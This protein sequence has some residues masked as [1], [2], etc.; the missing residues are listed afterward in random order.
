MSVQSGQGDFSAIAARNAVAAETLPGLDEV[1]RICALPAERHMEPGEVE[2][3]SRQELT[4][5]AWKSGMRLWRQQAEADMAFQSVGG[6]FAPLRVAGGKSIISYLAAKHAIQRTGVERVML[7]VPSDLISKSIRRDVPFMRETID[8]RPQVH[9]VGGLPPA[10]RLHL[11]RSKWR[12]VY[13]YPYSLL[14]EE[15]AD[16]EIGLIDPDVVVADE[17]HALRGIKTAAS[18]KRFMRMMADRPKNRRRKFAGLSGTMAKRSLK[19]YAHL[20]LLALPDNCPAPR[21]PAEVE[22]WASALDEV[23]RVWEEDDSLDSMRTLEPMRAWAEDH[24]KKGFFSVEEVGGPLTADAEG[25][26]RAFRLRRNSAQ[27]VVA[28]AESALGVSLKM[29]NRPAPAPV[30]EGM[31]E[32]AI[33]DLENSLD[34]RFTGEEFFTPKDVFEKEPP[35][36]KLLCLLWAV[37][38]I[39]TRKDR[40]GRATTPNGDVIEYGIHIHKWAYE[41]C[42]GFYHEMVWPTIDDLMRE[43]GVSRESAS[44]LLEMAEKHLAAERRKDKELRHFLTEM[45]HVQGVD[46]PMLVGAACKRNDPR[47]PEKLRRRWWEMHDLDFEGRP[48]RVS[49]PVR[50]CDWKIRSAIDWAKSEVKPDKGALIWVYN[51][52]VGE[53][54]AELFTEAFGPDRVLHCPSGRKYDE[55]IQSPEAAKKLVIAATGGSSGGHSRGKDLQHSFSENYF[56]QWPRS[57]DI[58]EQAIGRTHRDGQPADELRIFTNNTLGYDHMVFNA[59]LSDAMWAHQVEGEQKIIYADYPEEPRLFPDEFLRQRGF[60]LLAK[61]D[62]SAALQAILGVKAK[63]EAAA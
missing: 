62:V 9:A 14:R 16:E 41:L 53:W 12:G 40:K 15:Q 44:E 39:T 28:S 3:V 8:F 63:E 38:G 59:C 58:A 4:E 42:S 6:I 54:A 37:C 7:L 50:V 48:V 61:K 2:E 10:R 21:D 36:K 24:F 35:F 13:L 1:R 33:V 32:K 19:D 22:V 34:K 26:R 25:Y 20:V 29:V 45:D 60:D 49:N 11:C 56:L 52:E 43:R 46:T 47:V 30:S 23:G 5:K 57:H 17:C 18:T 31:D 27:G 51:K 55:L